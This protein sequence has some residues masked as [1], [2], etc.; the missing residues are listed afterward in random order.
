MGVKSPRS[1]CCSTVW[2]EMSKLLLRDLFF[3]QGVDFLLLGDHKFFWF[4]FSNWALEKLLSEGD[5]F[6][7]CRLSVLILIV[8]KWHVLRSCSLEYRSVLLFDVLEC[9][10]KVESFVGFSF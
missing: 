6:I 2:Q 8:R 7:S 9:S 10:L 5:L 1:I 4:N 3:G